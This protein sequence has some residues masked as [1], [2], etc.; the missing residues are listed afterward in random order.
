V[1]DQIAGCGQL[2]VGSSVTQGF[3][4]P[5]VLEAQFGTQLNGRAEPMTQPDRVLQVFGGEAGP[6]STMTD[7]D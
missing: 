2:I 6:L 3:L 5:S 1:G 7:L 4:I